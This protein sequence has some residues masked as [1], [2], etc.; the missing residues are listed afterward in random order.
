[1]ASDFKTIG[2]KLNTMG[3]IFSIE[4]LSNMGNHMLA[5]LTAF[6]IK[7]MQSCLN[8]YA[9]IIETFIRNLEASNEP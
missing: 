1:V 2:E 5:L 6:D 4:E 7:K 9:K 8:Y 3:E